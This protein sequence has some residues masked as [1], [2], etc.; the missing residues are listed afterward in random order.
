M[1]NET[2]SVS[3]EFDSYYSPRLSI[4]WGILLI[5]K[6]SCFSASSVTIEATERMEGRH[7][8][9][10]MVMCLLMNGING[11][12]NSDNALDIDFEIVDQPVAD[13]EQNVTKCPGSVQT[14][15]VNTTRALFTS[16]ILPEIEEQLVQK[17]Q[18]INQLNNSINTMKVCSI[19]YRIT[20][21]RS[22][23]FYH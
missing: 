12:N 11:Q 17:D 5:K 13:I 9:S 7:H 3:F 19:T 6:K 15:L 4:Y 20:R 2:F 23:I 18:M 10:F 1:L 16:E 14:F 21:Q 8:F 22:P